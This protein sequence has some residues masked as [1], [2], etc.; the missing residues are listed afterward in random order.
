MKQAKTKFTWHYYAMALGVLLA[1]LAMTLSAWS[2][3]L[4]ALGFSVIAHP[5]LQYKGMT[6]LIILAAFIFLYG[7]AFPDADVVRE[8]MPVSA[9]TE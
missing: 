8:M 1:L 6:R 5:K 9:I 3:A 4:S 2:S 7:F